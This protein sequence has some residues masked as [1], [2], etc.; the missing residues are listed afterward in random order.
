MSWWLV[1][2]AVMAAGLAGLVALA[3]RMGHFRP[4]VRHVLWLLVLVKLIAPPLFPWVGPT[5]PRELP[6]QPPLSAEADQAPLVSAAPEIE[7][8]LTAQSLQFK[9]LALEGQ[10]ALSETSVTQATEETKATPP[11]CIEAPG[12]VATGPSAV[13]LLNAAW[14]P[15]QV[16][17]FLFRLWVGAVAVM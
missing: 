4:A 10:T 12:I 16:E 7:S 3:C 17:E 11:A 5:P 6:I 13:S 2:N 15:D 8:N 14:L 1:Q 9:W